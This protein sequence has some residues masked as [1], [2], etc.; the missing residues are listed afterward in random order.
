MKSEERH[1]LETNVLAKYLVEFGQKYGKYGSH[2]LFAVIALLAVV[3]IWRISS[4][5]MRAGATQAW[6]SVAGAMAQFPPNVETLTATSETYAGKTAGDAAGLGVADMKL[7]EATLGFFSNKAEAME[8]IGEAKEIYESLAKS[9]KNDLI[10]NRAKF[11]AARVKEIEGDIPGAIAAYG[12]VGGIL[13]QM[14][15]L[16]AEDLEALGVESYAAWLRDAEGTARQNPLDLFTSPEFGADPLGLPSDSGT[17]GTPLGEEELQQFREFMQ[18]LPEGPADNRYDSKEGETPESSPLLPPLDAPQDPEA[19]NA[20]LPGQ[21]DL[22]PLNPPAG[23]TPDAPAS[24]PPAD[25]PESPAEDA[26]AEDS[27]ATPPGE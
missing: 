19:P 6:D 10:R 17:P 27:P 22:G 26:P 21:L 15:K 7:A 20:E 5:A 23:D 16:R 12:D 18:N 1:E 13:A 9:T 8:K 24:E 25:T 2:A 14:A 11:G 4:S 3:A